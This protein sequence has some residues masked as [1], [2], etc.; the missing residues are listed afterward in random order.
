MRA[1]P[2]RGLPANIDALVIGGGD[3]IATDLYAGSSSHDHTADRDRD[4]FELDA[5]RHA[6]TH[7]LPILGICRGAQ[8]L[9]VAAG[10]T[11]HTDISALREH[12]SN[13]VNPFACQTA[14]VMAGSRL[15][16]LVGR[17]LRINSL[18]HQAIDRLGNALAVS[19]RDADDFVQA[20]ETTSHHFVVGVQWHPEYLLYRQEQ[21]RLFKALIDASAYRYAP[22]E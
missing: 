13:R 18:H 6:H 14:T 22:G 5:I 11:L 20:I 1:T 3:D 15:A 8:L 2:K 9:N 16:A 10:G 19:A 12:T 7:D 21:R 17:K 4:A